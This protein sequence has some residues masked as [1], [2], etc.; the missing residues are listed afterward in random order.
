MSGGYER[1]E[2]ASF[3]RRVRRST[4]EVESE[5]KLLR[6]N[7]TTRGQEGAAERVIEQAPSSDPP[8]GW[9]SRDVEVSPVD[10]Q[11]SVIAEELRS[12][13]AQTTR[14]CA[15]LERER[16]KYVD[17]FMNA[18][19]S[20]VVTDQRGTIQE[21]NL[22][23]GRLLH[24]GRDL[25]PGR[26]LIGFVARRD[27]ALFRDFVRALGEGRFSEV[28]RELLVRLRPRGGQPFVTAVRA[29][30]LLG[31]AGKLVALRW[32]LRATEAGD[33]RAPQTVLA[34]VM[35][36]LV[37]EMRGPVGR[38][39]GCAEQLRRR[40]GG[41]PELAEKLALLEQAAQMQERSLGD[42]EE[43]ADTYDGPAARPRERVDLAEQAVAVVEALKRSRPSA[44]FA[45]QRPAES[46]RV[47][48]SRARLCRALEILLGRAAAATPAEKV[49]PLRVE[50]QQDQAVLATKSES[51]QLPR[52]WNIRI[53]TA[54]RIINAEGGRLTLGADAPCV[55]LRLPLARQ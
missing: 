46:V 29:F 26:P 4:A 42:L 40:R 18:S 16:L 47:M 6:A 21:A 54:T 27:T 53:A 41:E 37:E 20:Y 14:A 7:T 23:V 24:V 9:R 8:S 12:Q 44:R 48:A 17:L 13:I 19:D 15:L 2:V 3:V 34:E 22:A 5:L 51:G 43:L 33:D 35:R 52:G 55:L 10:A 30:P 38:V 28:P 25:L 45:L 11:V 32:T 39:T 36:S 1:D 49:I 31:D 50:V